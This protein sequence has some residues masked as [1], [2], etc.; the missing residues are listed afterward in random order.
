M[1]TAAQTPPAPAPA[2]APEPGPEQWRAFARQD[3]QAAYDIYV[4]NHPGMHDHTNRGFPAQ[5]KRARDAGL[6]VAQKASSRADY[7]DA[8]GAF[9]SELS[10]GHAQAFAIQPPAAAGP[11]PRQWPGFVATYRGKD[12]VVHHAGP[13]SPVPAGAIVRACNGKPINDLIKTR[14]L[15]RGFRPAEAGIWWFRTHQAF[16]ASPTTMRHLPET[17][18]FRM[19]GGKEKSVRLDW[20]PAPDNLT[21]LLEAATDGERTPIGL[22][23]PRPGMFLV[24]LQD[25]QPNEESVKAYRAL[26]ETLR[27]RRTELMKAKAIVLDLRYNNGG[28]SSWPRQAAQ[29]I[30]GDEPVTTAM[31]H[32][33]NKVRIWWRASD[34]NIDYMPKMEAAV[35]RNGNTGAADGT[36]RT[37]EGMVAAKARGELFFRR[38]K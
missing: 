36:K 3:V 37:W 9:S 2:A 18:T 35:R 12:V 1:P 5:L 6:K 24:G 19:P 33:F 23:E 11:V 28:S 15:S 8:L 38:G 14:L 34:G 20:S 25:F 31:S 22:T 4:A 21:S 32:F 26:F 10:D 7:Q 16:V 29:A 30:W 17:C 13:A 27:A